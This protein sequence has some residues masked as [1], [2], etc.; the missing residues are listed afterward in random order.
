MS[1]ND[2][3][4]SYGWQMLL[5]LA[6]VVVV[7]GGMK[8]ASVIIVP[9]LLALVI[10]IILLPPLNWL[11]EHGVA[12]IF[13]IPII[14][15]VVVCG[16]IGIGLI[17]GNSTTNFVHALPTYQSRLNELTNEVISLAH[18]VGLH[19]SSHSIQKT[20][21]PNAAFGM[22]AELLKSFGTL[23]GNGFLIFLTVLFILFEASV[24]PAK[25][26]RA[27][28]PG[29]KRSLVAFR[30]FMNGVQRYIG[31][32]TLTS[33]ATGIWVGV[34]LWLMG[35]HYPVL[36]GLLMF[37]LNFVPNIG[38]IIAAIP[39]VLLAYLQDGMAMAGGTV[40]LY[41]VA[42]TVIGNFVEPR[43]MGQRLGLSTLVVFISLIWWGWVL[44]PIGMLL[45]VP[46][47][48]FVKIGLETSE[49]TR[50]VAVLLS[51]TPGKPLFRAHYPT[52]DL[53]RRWGFWG[54]NRRNNKK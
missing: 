17:I 20:L 5:G 40:A 38:P 36:W 41:T 30:Q 12:P 21:N 24:L 52:P 54:S 53:L 13:A 28:T 49:S 32:K 31:L 16:L 47:T 9:F 51:S 27:P 6:A 25:F 34:A 26:A 23:L 44:G 37:L 43:L 42:N 15:I 29:S 45:S 48:M 2:G 7:I 39:A 18:K 19:F 3:N 50:W 22:V 33:M 8:M 14:L 1:D 10:A 35:V 46:L 4:L 11:R